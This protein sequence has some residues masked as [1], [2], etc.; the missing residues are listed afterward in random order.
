MIIDTSLIFDNKVFVLNDNPII[1]TIDTE[2]AKVTIIDN[3][4]EDIQSVTNQLSKLSMSLIWEQDDNNITF[5][6]A[7]KVYS[8]NMK[9]TELTYVRNESLKKLVSNIVDYPA[10]SLLP[11]EDFVVN[12]FT[13]TDDFDSFLDENYYGCHRD[14]HTVPEY[15]GCKSTGQIAL[16]I[17]LNEHYEEGEGLNFY[18]VPNDV[19]VVIRTKKSEIKKIH[20]VQ[21]KQNRA[22]LFDS[23][24]PH[25]QHTPTNQFKNEMRYTQ[26]IFVP[27]F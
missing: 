9:G 18:N 19:D 12:C 1:E 17:F 24:F 15:D 13:F 3:F 20:T 27:T 26:V 25:G 22:V 2:V 5:L 23:Q 10:Q 14:N 7:R 4:Y 16:V 11:S 21:G 6:D 8:G